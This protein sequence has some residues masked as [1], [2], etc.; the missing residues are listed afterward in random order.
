MK[1]NIIPELIVEIYNI[2]YFIPDIHPNQLEN[3]VI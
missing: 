2:D 3:L 1:F